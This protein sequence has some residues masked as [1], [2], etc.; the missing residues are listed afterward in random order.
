[1]GMLLRNLIIT[2]CQRYGNVTCLLVSPPTAAAPDNST[3]PLLLL[4][5]SVAFLLFFETSEGSGSR[6]YAMTNQHVL[7]LATKLS[8][9]DSPDSNSMSFM[10]PVIWRYL[11]WYILRHQY[12]PSGSHARYLF[13][14][15]MRKS[16]KW[17]DF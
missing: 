8:K 5:V 12:F 6:L 1:M 3:S 9:P 7:T 4:V 14:D 11:V 15:F 10:L 17:A 2:F 16:I 13:R